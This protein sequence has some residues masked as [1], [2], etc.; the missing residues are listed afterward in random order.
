MTKKDILQIGY[1]FCTVS[2]IVTAVSLASEV[3]YTKFYVPIAHPRYKREFSD[4]DIISSNGDG[5]SRS[6]VAV[7]PQGIYILAYGSMAK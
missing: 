5:F 7:Y 2:N 1:D 3:G 6:L 4:K